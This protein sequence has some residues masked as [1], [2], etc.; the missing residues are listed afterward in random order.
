MGTE[1]FWEDVVVAVV[2]GEDRHTVL[3][4]DVTDDRSVVDVVHRE[5][6]VVGVAQTVAVGDLEGEHL[7]T[8]LVNSGREG[9]VLTVEHGVHEVIVVEGHLSALGHDPG[10]V[11]LFVLHV[12]SQVG[13]AEGE[14]TGVFVLA[15]V[16]EAVVGVGS[17]RVDHWAGTLDVNRA[18][19]VG[20]VAGSSHVAVVKDDVG[21]HGDVLNGGPVVGTGCGRLDHQVVVLL[22][23]GR[24]AALVGL[25]DQNFRGQR[26]ISEVAVGQLNGHELGEVLQGSG[27]VQGLGWVDHTDISRG[28]GLHD[29]HDV[30][31]VWHTAN[32]APWNTE[33][34]ERGGEVHIDVCRAQ[35]GWAPAEETVAVQV[36]GTSAVCPQ[37]VVGVEGQVVCATE[38][39]VANI[40]TTATGVEVNQH[41]RVGQVG[42]GHTEVNA[43]AFDVGHQEVVGAVAA[44]HTGHSVAG[45]VEG[46]AT[47]PVL[48]R[49][50]DRHGLRL[51][52]RGDVGSTLVV[53]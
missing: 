53:R 43:V 12:V 41:V 47:V 37:H 28:F 21:G 35:R 40:G 51:E 5:G 52:G 3:A 39:V 24:G 32:A 25:V 7:R 27:T 13:Q 4:L 15:E 31:L 6:D 14:G 18:L 20:R 45:W 34:S 42:V 50:V 33:L 46:V 38:A 44:H 10:Q 48:V 19:N 29:G 30:N 26:T 8:E 22:T 1:A 11:G 23:G 36:I 16:N 17:F 49:T 9:H 2:F